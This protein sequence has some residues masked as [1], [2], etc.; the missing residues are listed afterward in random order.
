MRCHIRY[1]LAAVA[2]LGPVAGCGWQSAP[3]SKG[4]AGAVAIIDLDE[5]A[6]RLGS[7]RQIA[8]S[9]NQRQTALRQQLVELAQ[10]YS[11]QIADQRKS[12]PAEQPGQ[13]DVTLAGWEQQANANLNQVKQQAELDLLNHRQRLM[14]QFRDQVKPVA[15]RVAQQRGLSVIVT[16]ND[17]VIFDYAA[18]ADITDEVVDELLAASAPA[19]MPTSQSATS[20]PAPQ[21]AAAPGETA[22]R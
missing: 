14:A 13:A 16:K 4:T 5:I 20:S 12:L 9:L 6:R 7:D 19:A 3:N 11:Q 1:V 17:T 8:D 22:T 10:S 2:A 21:Q 15:R 18:G